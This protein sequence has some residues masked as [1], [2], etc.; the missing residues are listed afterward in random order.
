MAIY[1]HPYTTI[2]LDDIENISDC[3]MQL[4]KIAFVQGQ[5]H[6]TGFVHIPIQFYITNRAPLISYCCEFS[7]VRPAG[8][9]ET[10]LQLLYFIN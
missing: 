7:V 10:S 5:K 8:F 6:R 2:T 9:K 1:I 3:S 4:G